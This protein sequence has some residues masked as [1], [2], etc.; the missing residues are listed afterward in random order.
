[1]SAY[2]A[3]ISCKAQSGAPLA[4]YSI[5]RRSMYN[6]ETS[7]GNS[8][9]CSLICLCCAKRYPFKSDACA[10][11]M[12][13]FTP[14]RDSSRQTFMGLSREQ[15]AGM[16][17][18]ETY[19]N[20]YGQV[21]GGPNLLE[22]LHEFDDWQLVMP[23]V[24]GSLRVLC[25]PEDRPCS[26]HGCVL[27]GVLCADCSL[28]LCSE[29]AGFMCGSG[30][31]MPPM[32]LSNVMMAFYA[33]S[34]LYEKKVAL[35]ELICASVCLTSMVCFT[36]EKKYRGDGSL[37]DI[38]VHM[39]RHRVDARGNMSTVPLPWMDILR[40]LHRFGPDQASDALDLP[41][42]G[43]DIAT[44]VQVLIKCNDD[45]SGESL[46]KRLH[47]AVVR[48]DVVV[49]LIADMK[50]RRHPAY[51]DVCMVKVQE[52]AMRMLPRSGFPEEIIKLLPWDP[53]DE[54]FDKIQVKKAATPTPSFAQNDEELQAARHDT[55]P[56]AVVCEK[57]LDDG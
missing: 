17:G 45:D 50:R 9:V 23:F 6:Y 20:A 38:P 7:L 51:R 31:Q 57:S 36:L 1:M 28:P 53:K 16:F 48:A 27:C 49:E 13:W 40:A 2:C 44:W 12:S 14:F 43:G 4:A 54:V 34:I 19:L 42:A 18:L 8:D 47:Q 32:A 21:T 46:A 24:S 55:A 29:C 11:Y 3:G 56:N 52:K 26:H 25:C 33:P 30:P 41:N 10:A 5:D 15:V 39:Q 37:W 35:M 22:P